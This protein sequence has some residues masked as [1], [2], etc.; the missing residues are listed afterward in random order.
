MGIRKDRVCLSQSNR[1][2]NEAAIGDLQIHINIGD[3]KAI[4][5]YALA[6]PT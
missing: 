4:L 6:P 1:K 3:F 2:G 5:E